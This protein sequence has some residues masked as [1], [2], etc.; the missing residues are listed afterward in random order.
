M[1]GFGKTEQVVPVSYSDGLLTFRS[2]EAYKVGKSTKVQLLLTIADKLETPSISVLIGSVEDVEEG[3]FLCTGALQLDGRRTSELVAKLTYAGVE[4]ACRRSSRRIDT[5]VRILS[6][7]LPGFHAVTKDVNLSGV[8]LVCDGPV[9]PGCYLNLTFD[10]EVVGFP[11]LTMQAQCVRCVDEMVGARNARKCRL[12]VAFTAQHPETHAAWAKFYHHLLG[13]KNASLMGKSLG[14]GIGAELRERALSTGRIPDPQ[15][16]PPVPPTPRTEPQPRADSP[17]PEPSPL[18]SPQP[19][20]HPSSP[21]G[22][23]LSDSSSFQMP[24]APSFPPAAQ[25]TGGI[26][27]QELQQPSGLAFPESIPTIASFEPLLTAPQASPRHDFRPA[28]PAGYQEDAEPPPVQTLGI[29]GANIIFRALDDSGFQVGGVRM[30]AVELTYHG[31]WTTLELSVTLN[32]VET[33]AS[34]LC[35]CWGTLREDPRVV[36]M[37]NQAL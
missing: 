15:T 31:Q 27:A 24:S 30:V 2:T 34:G 19:A 22:P 36:E 5:M 8:Q 35:T 1:F 32:K 26:A 10:L 18:P 33:S 13:H 37:L 29:D 17:Y 14:S 9:E 16:P 6:K 25:P 23:E 7:D 28:T 11:E 20:P 21:S 4:G 3:S 12:G